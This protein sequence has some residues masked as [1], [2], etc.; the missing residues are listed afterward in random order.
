MNN[1]I[2]QLR[3]VCLTLP[4]LDKPILHSVNYQVN[5]GDFVIL[6]GSNGSGKSSLLKLLDRRYQR[7][8][9]DIIFNGS[10]LDTFRQKDLA[11]SISTLTQNCGDSLFGTLTVLENCKLVQFRHKSSRT[12]FSKNNTKEFFGNYLEEFNCNLPDKLNEITSNLSGGEQQA[13]ALALSL[14]HPPQILLLD[15]HTS[16]LDPKIA[17]QLMRFTDVLIKKHNITCILTTHDLDIAANYGNKILALRNGKVHCCI[18]KYPGNN[19]T[20]EDLLEVCY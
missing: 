7:T 5:S 13:L 19:Y 9:G 17:V 8:A 16:A 14:L 20:I 15:E 10:N 4:S 3:D 1:N 12:Q 6:L 2:L 18:D 11:K